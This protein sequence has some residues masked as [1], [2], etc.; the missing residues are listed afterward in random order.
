MPPPAERLPGN[1]SWLRGLAERVGAGDL[2]KKSGRAGPVAEGRLAGGE[3]R[4][5]GEEEGQ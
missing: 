1:H 4:Y 5:G 3:R 2:G